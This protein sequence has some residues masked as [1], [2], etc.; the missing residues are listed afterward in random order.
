MIKIDYYKFDVYEPYKIQII[1]EHLIINL[2]NF[3]KKTA[4]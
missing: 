4:F 2:Q 1:L 3:R